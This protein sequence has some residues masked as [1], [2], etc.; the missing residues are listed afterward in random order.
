MQLDWVPVSKGDGY[1]V[2]RGLETVLDHLGHDTDYPNIGYAIG[3]LYLAHLH[4]K[5]TLQELRTFGVRDHPNQAKFASFIS[6]WTRDS[7]A[8]R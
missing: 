8:H 5:H 1:R 6:A 3:Y 4:G 7:S 2:A